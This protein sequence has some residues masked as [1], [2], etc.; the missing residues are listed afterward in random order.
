M[1]EF[2]AAKDRSS[3][4]RQGGAVGVTVPRGSR[5]G[6]IGGKEFRRLSPLAFAGKTTE[7]K[8]IS[9][10]DASWLIMVETTQPFGKLPGLSMDERVIEEEKRLGGDCCGPAFGG[11][12]VRVGTVEER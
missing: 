10:C 11:A 9:S 7:G 12:G 2:T 4:C 1:E 3:V 8:T 6:A 5:F